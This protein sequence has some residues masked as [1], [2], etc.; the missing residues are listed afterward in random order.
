MTPSWIELAGRNAAAEAVCV[1]GTLT[2]VD[3]NESVRL[4]FWYA[5][6]GKWRVEREAQPMYIASETTAVAWVDGKMHRLDGE[7]R[8]PMLD[9]GFSPLDL[10]G[11]ESLLRKMSAAMTVEGEATRHDIGG[12]AG[13]SI[14]LRAPNRE[15]ITLTFDDATGVLVGLHTADGA[16][17]LTVDDLMSPVS[18]PDSLFVWD[19]PVREDVRPTRGHRPRNVDAET[20]HFE[21]LR[22]IVAA[23]AQP[24]RVMSVIVE[25]GSEIAA[26]AALIELLGVTESGANLILATPI[27]IFRGD[28]SVANR[29][30][31]ESMEDRRQQ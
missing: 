15:P 23:Q 11:S 21:A 27:G 29:R 22:A 17:R 4:N 5:P 31:L 10:L 13:W 2:I 24:H 1:N 9:A 28:H 18:L 20:E 7:I 3:P 12:R 14:R 8:M 16:R 6:G 30:T 26:R 25:A 19:G